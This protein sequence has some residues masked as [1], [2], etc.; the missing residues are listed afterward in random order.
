MGE[1][2]IPISSPFVVVLDETNFDS[3]IGSGVVLVD[4]WASWCGP[5]RM[6]GPIVEQVGKQVQGKAKVAKLDVDAAPQVAR[7]FKI[8]S[9]PTL[10]V[11]KDG[12]PR[13][14]FVGVTKAGTLLSAV[15][16]ALDS[17]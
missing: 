1:K 10:I 2:Q 5:C 4:F 14:Q 16:S 7:K 6:Q 17:E 13:D 3:E 9:I 15:T 11:F 8:R 12:K